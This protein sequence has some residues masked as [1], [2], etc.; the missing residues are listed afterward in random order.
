MAAP[1][2]PAT[3]PGLCLSPHGELDSGGSRGDSPDQRGDRR[4][5]RTR[6][7]AADEVAG[8]RG[9][10]ARAEARPDRRASHQ[11]L[12]LHHRPGR[13]VGPSTRDFVPR[14]GIPV[15]L[16]PFDPDAPDRRY[17]RR[18]LDQPQ[19]GGADGRSVRRAAA[20]GPHDRARGHPPTRRRV[21]D[22]FLPHRRGGERADPAGGPPLRRPADRVRT[23]PD[24]DRRRRRR[25]GEAARQVRR[26]RAARRLTAAAPR[27]RLEGGVPE[28]R[29]HEPASSARSPSSS[30]TVT[31][32]SSALPSF[33]PGFS[34]TTT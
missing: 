18:P 12:R 8:R 27:R 22:R 29:P 9:R 16:A 7:H 2:G 5:D 28:P 10:A 11:R 19:S 33:E 20:D 24:A 4:M 26:Y 23:D 34:P 3:S 25:H 1:P 31:P 32:S 21:E 30:S 14:Q 15:P 6:H 13:E 17:P